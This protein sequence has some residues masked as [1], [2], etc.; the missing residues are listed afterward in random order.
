MAAGDLHRLEEA[1][2]EAWSGR[3]W[4]SAGPNGHSDRER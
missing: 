4:Q 2:E 1:A 3:L